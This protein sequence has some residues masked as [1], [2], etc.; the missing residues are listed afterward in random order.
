MLRG[1]TKWALLY[2]CTF[3]S[4]WAQ[5]F[6]LWDRTVQ[7]HGFA[8]EGYVRTDENNWLTMNTTNG[9]WSMSDM[10]LNLSSQVTDRLR[11]GA[12][13][14][15]RDLGAL[16]DWHPSVDWAV[17]DYRVTNWLG[18]RGGKVKTQLGLYND[19]QDLE[20]LHVFALLP[21]GTYPTDLRDTTIA[22]RGADM[23]GNVPLQHG[24]GGLSYTAYGG[25]RSDSIYSGY[26]YVLQQFEVYFHSLG[27]P[28][29]GADLRWNTPWKGLLVGVSRMN[30]RITGKGSFVNLL[31]PQ[32]GVVPYE[33]TTKADWT[34]QFY[35]QYEIHRLRV[36]AEYR[37]H[38]DKSPYI[39]GSDSFTDSRSWYVSG[40]WR[41]QRHL[42]IGSY[43]SHYTVTHAQGGPAAVLS[44]PQTDSSQPQNHVYDKVAAARIDVNRFVYLKVEGHFMNGYGISSYPD[45]FYPQQ[46]PQWFKPSTSALIVKTGFHF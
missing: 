13:V 29:Y 6:R 33:T 5:D 14:Y 15:D 32:A 40:T 28:Q 2:F 38:F 10:G 45:G 30:Q 24:W 20:F 35:G 18:I 34:N 23:Y 31:N 17:A 37:R 39:P 8:S 4:A 46:N 27:G 16:G 1:I 21:Q 3:G 22:H 43:Y 19:S 9:A 11:V 25:Y 12:Q 7:V 26:P 44:T 36:D 41:V 42:A